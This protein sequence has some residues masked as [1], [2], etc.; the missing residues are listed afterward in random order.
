MPRLRPRQVEGQE[1]GT[2]GQGLGQGMC[3]EA[4]AAVERELCPF[5]LVLGTHCML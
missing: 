5:R 3:R 1:A 2:A 4:A